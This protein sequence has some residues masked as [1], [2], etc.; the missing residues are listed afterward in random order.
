MIYM[1][2]KVPPHFSLA[3]F[4]ER[5]E[6]PIRIRLSDVEARAQESAEDATRRA[7]E[8]GDEPPMAFFATF[9]ETLAA[10]RKALGSEPINPYQVSSGALYER[11]EVIAASKKV[12]EADE[13]TEHLGIAISITH[14]V[15]Q[16]TAKKILEDLLGEDSDA[17]IAAL[18]IQGDPEFE[19][20]ADTIDG[21]E[22]RVRNELGIP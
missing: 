22:R 8:A 17:K 9:L 19:T 15:A 20:F 7:R 5:E 10:L 13:E 21:L 2:F 3:T 18:K 4:T 11:P 6:N 1:Q 14:L 16:E 12:D